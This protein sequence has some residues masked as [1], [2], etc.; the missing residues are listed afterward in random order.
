MGG[1]NLRRHVDGKPG[2][3][4]IQALQDILGNWSFSSAHWPRE[5]YRVLTQDQSLDQQVIAN[6]VHCRNYNLIEG[7][8]VEEN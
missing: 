2:P 6:C 1:T 7:S 4:A 3:V 8:T 5:E